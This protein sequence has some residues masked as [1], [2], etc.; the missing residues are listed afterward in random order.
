MGQRL[1]G[2]LTPQL[3]HHLHPYCWESAVGPE[4][5]ASCKFLSLNQKPTVTRAVLKLKLDSYEVL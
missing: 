4:S 2:V 1:A 5:V 3:S